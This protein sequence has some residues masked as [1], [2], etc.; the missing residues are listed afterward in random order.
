MSRLCR[1][2]EVYFC[3]RFAGI[4][5]ETEEGYRFTYSDG[6]RTNGAPIGYGFPVSEPMYE[7][8]HFPPLFDNLVSEGWMRR[9]QSLNQKI[10]EDDRF[11]LLMHNGA[12]LV[13]AI[14]VKRMNDE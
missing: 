10:S 8:T 7:F 12:D 1:R 11:G 5:E 3:D 4:L 13:G 14:T 9:T 2:C 6:Y